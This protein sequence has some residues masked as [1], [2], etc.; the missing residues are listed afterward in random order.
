MGL[1]LRGIS[2]CLSTMCRHSLTVA[3]P[4]QPDHLVSWCQT[5]SLQGM[6]NTLLLFISTSTLLLSALCSSGPNGLR[7]ELT[8]S[9]VRKQSLTSCGRGVNDLKSKSVTAQSL[10]SFHE[11]SLSKR[12]RMGSHSSYTQVDTQMDKH[13]RRET[14]QSALGT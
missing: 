13:L 10:C 3:H 5:S 11:K 9:M 12:T 7:Q 2:I 6:R 1:A 4:Q 14:T 8:Y